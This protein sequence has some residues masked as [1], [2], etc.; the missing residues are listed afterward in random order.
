MLRISHITHILSITKSFF[1]H[2]SNIK[3]ITSY[4]FVRII[5]QS[6]LSLNRRKT[7][8]IITVN[9]CIVNLAYDKV[10]TRT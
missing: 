8:V 4:E 9:Q 3:T 10:C 7:L 5:E 2:W 6:Q 1:R